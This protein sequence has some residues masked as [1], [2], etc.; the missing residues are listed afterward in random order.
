M[1]QNITRPIFQMGNHQLTIINTDLVEAEALIKDL[2]EQERLTRPKSFAGLVA[3]VYFKMPYVR[4]CDGF[5]E[6]RE[7]IRCVYENTGL[8]ANYNGIVAIEAT[9]WIGHERE[10]YF[11]IILKYLYEQRNIWQSAIIL[12]NCPPSKMLCFVS[13][14]SRYMK[15]WVEE[16][17]LFESASSLGC[18]IQA[19]FQKKNI[20]INRTAEAMLAEAMVR[21]ELKDG[22]SLTFIERVV[23][24]II[25]SNG[26][27]SQITV[28][29]IRD[30]LLD[31]Y[32]N[33]ALM[34]GKVIYN[35]REMIHEKE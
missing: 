11:T 35:E 23:D 18:I 12:K 25:S 33:I 9:E 13:A 28:D 16:L 24:E 8:R 31:S 17:K 19:E 3:C 1:S 20:R 14:C 4:P 22:R 15:P 7:L 34:A 10:L 21:P 32:S 27:R 6:L 30:Y 5:G 29:K 26:N 2:A